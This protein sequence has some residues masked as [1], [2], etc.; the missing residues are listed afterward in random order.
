MIGRLLEHVY[1]ALVLPLRSSRPLFGRLLELDYV[2]VAGCDGSSRPLVGRLLEQGLR[3]AGP[4]AE[5]SGLNP[6]P[7]ASE[8]VSEAER[9]AG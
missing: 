4:Q 5:I 6:R 8:L 1:V 9:M 3:P 7:K 2:L